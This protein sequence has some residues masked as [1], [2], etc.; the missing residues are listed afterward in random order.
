MLVKPRFVA[1][2]CLF[3]ILSCYLVLLE[4]GSTLRKSM[5]TSSSGLVATILT[6][7]AAFSGIV[8]RRMQRLQ[9]LALVSTSPDILGQ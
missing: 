8:S 2:G 6:S 1:T 9:V 7:G 3:S 4:S 5:H